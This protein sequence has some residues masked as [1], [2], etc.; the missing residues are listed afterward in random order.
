M[1]KK[2]IMDYKH[3][4]SYIHLLCIHNEYYD[5]CKREIIKK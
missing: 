3:I 5:S 4:I 1:I 2:R